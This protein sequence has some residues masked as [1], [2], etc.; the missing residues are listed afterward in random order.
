MS[1]RYPNE[2]VKANE[3]VTDEALNDGFMPAA[4]E[5]QGRIN[6]HNLSSGI[7]QGTAFGGAGDVFI[8]DTFV[9]PTGFGLEFVNTR[10][11]NQTLAEG[12]TGATRGAWTTTDDVTGHNVTADSPEFDGAVRVDL[13]PAWNIIGANRP[14]FQRPPAEDEARPMQVSFFAEEE[15]TIWVMATLQA[16]DA[17]TGF[18]QMFCLRVNGAIISESVYGSADINN[19]R[20]DNRAWSIDTPFS[21]VMRMSPAAGAVGNEVGY[22]VCVECVITIPPGDTV[23]E[24]MALNAATIKGNA[25]AGYAPTKKVFIGNREIVILKMKR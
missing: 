16:H 19:E 17:S 6:E 1:W 8:S 23:V 3:V 7:I 18:G 20:I 25:L 21:E 10:G 14:P 2:I 15:M 22:P 24:V 5:A 4:S 11:Q 9:E 12:G 13:S